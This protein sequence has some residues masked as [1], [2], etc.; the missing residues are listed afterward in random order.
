MPKL[1]P[2]EIAEE[3]NEQEESEPYEEGL[4]SMAEIV[5]KQS[6]DLGIGVFHDDNREKIEV[7]I[8][9]KLNAY[10]LQTG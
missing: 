8:S 7:M 2:P 5:D 3:A 6:V 1:K 9:S 10:A 4:A